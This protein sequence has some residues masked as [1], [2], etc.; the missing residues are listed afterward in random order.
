MPA[1]PNCYGA[2]A[3]IY[4]LWYREEPLPYT[5]WLFRKIRPENQRAERITDL[6]CGTGT[7]AIS[8][9]KLGKKVCGVDMSLQM[10]RKAR[11]KASG[12]LGI[13]WIEA[14]M[15]QFRVPEPQDLV[16]CAFDSVNHL[17]SKESL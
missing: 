17:T 1:G 9:A 8:A 6:A 14:R 16:I 5:E 2:L 4:D 10:L 13:R 3:D 7:L 12:R 11:S 15:E